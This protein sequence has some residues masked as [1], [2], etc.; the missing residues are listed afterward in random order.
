MDGEGD[1]FLPGAGFPRQEYRRLRRRDPRDEVEHFAPALRVPDDLARSA[2]VGRERFHHGS[3]APL[4]ALL[5]LARFRGEP[6]FLRQLLVREHQRDLIG[7]PAGDVGVLL[8]ILSHRPREEI[9]AADDLSLQPH[10]HAQERSHPLLL[11]A[12]VLL[13]AAPGF[14]PKVP[15][16][17]ETPIGVGLRVAIDRYRLGHVRDPVSRVGVDPD[18]LAVLREEAQRHPV[19]R[20]DP[21]DGGGEL[22]EDVADVE[23]LRQRRQKRLE[24]LAPAPALP[25]LPEE[26]IVPERHGDEVR[27]REH[28]G[29]VL[30]IEGADLG[31]ENQIVPIGRAAGSRQDISD[32]QSRPRIRRSRR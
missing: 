32:R 10:G 22:V 5:L 9:Q 15:N 16:E 2:E 26:P 30:R 4:E 20:Q 27:D 6:G 1:D 14:L 28:R 13:A 31:E 21:S 18:R 19:V 12:F 25:L 17:E 11:H 3:Q 8:A 7:D 23:R 29:L 24:R